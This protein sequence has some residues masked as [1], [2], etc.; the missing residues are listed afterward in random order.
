MNYLCK[1]EGAKIQYSVT[2]TRATPDSRTSQQIMRLLQKRRFLRDTGLTLSSKSRQPV[3]YP[4][5]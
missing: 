3:I 2:D 5:D 1:K 4:N